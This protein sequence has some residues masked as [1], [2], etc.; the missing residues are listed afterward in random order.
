ME[1]EDGVTGGNGWAGGA[2]MAG[3]VAWE[4]GVKPINTDMAG[5][6]K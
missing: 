4:E 3:A 2:G 5:L 1:S 6:E